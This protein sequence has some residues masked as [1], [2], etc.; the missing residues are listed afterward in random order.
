MSAVRP[1]V[2]ARVRAPISTTTSTPRRSLLSFVHITV[3][4]D[5]K[6]AQGLQAESRSSGLSY[7]GSE[8]AFA[9]AAIK[10]LDS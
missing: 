6:S 2:H 8:M 1:H 10:L 4:I 9:V 5:N 3:E 7:D